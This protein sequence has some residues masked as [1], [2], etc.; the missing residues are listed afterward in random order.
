M[1]TEDSLDKLKRLVVSRVN[2]CP[3]TPEFLLPIGVVCGEAVPF[4]SSFP[5]SLLA[6]SVYASLLVRR[7]ARISFLILRNNERDCHCISFLHR[8]TSKQV[9]L[10]PTTSQLKD[11]RSTTELLRWA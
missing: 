1:I 5:E 4:R 3:S 2:R 8:L 6:V 9:G 10:E 11:N 7:Q